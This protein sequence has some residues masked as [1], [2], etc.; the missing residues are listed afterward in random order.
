MAVVKEVSTHQ[1]R[2][3][4]EL[5]SKRKNA[6]RRYVISPAIWVKLMSSTKEER[7]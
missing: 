4:L 6:P 3:K 7:V 2:R 5:I 1:D